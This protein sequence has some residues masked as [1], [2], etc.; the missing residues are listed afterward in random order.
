MEQTPVTHGHPINPNYEI[1]RNIKPFKKPE[2]LSSLLLVLLLAACFGFSLVLG[3]TVILDLISFNH[4]HSLFCLVRF[5]S[6]KSLSTLVL[7]YSE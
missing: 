3:Q 6:T 7:F 1:K 2:R 5:Q 4:I